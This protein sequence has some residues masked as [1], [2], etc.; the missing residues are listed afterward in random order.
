MNIG[1]TNIFKYDI[2]TG[3]NTL[4]VKQAYKSNSV[5]KIFI[6]NEIK[7]M[8]KREIIRKLKSP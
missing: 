6:E 5:K 8:K 1:R 4:I 7:D 3:N 2:N